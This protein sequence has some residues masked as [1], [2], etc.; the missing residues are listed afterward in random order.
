MPP[1]SYLCLGLSLVAVGTLNEVLQLD[2]TA[3]LLSALAI[4]IAFLAGFL[5]GLRKC[6][7]RGWT[8]IPF[9]IAYVRLFV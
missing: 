4:V 6:P 8:P 7:T 3:K 2:E 1:L 9:F 5:H